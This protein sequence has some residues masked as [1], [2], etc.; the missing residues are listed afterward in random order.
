[1]PFSLKTYWTLKWFPSF[2]A[3]LIPKIAMLFPC[4]VSKIYW[5]NSYTCLNMIIIITS[6][7]TAKFWLHVSEFFHLNFWIWASNDTVQRLVVRS[8]IVLIAVPNFRLMSWTMSKSESFNQAQKIGDHQ[9][10]KTISS[11][12]GMLFHGTHGFK[13]LPKHFCKFG[14]QP[15]YVSY[16]F[17]WTRFE[18]GWKL[19]V[20]VFLVYRDSSSHPQTY[21]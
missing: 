14:N 21:A 17:P 1:M 8:T 20:K 13:C 2:S 7:C 4:T 6:L 10:C 3:P 11:F 16:L 9:T 18:H 5:G 12:F 15:E 19:D